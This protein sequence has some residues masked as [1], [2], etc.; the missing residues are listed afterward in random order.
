MQQQ[1]VYIVSVKNQKQCS[2]TS[3]TANG[4]KSFEDHMCTSWWKV[5]RSRY[6]A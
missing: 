4:S 5:Q 1:L 6:F 2:T 3:L